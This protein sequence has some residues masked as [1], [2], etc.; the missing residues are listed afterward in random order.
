[1]TADCRLVRPEVGPGAAVL[2]PG[3]VPQG[4]LQVGQR[5]LAVAALAAAHQRHVGRVVPLVGHVQLRHVQL[6]VLPHREGALAE[7]LSIVTGIY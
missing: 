6:L 3:L 7:Q 2:G 5:S 4:L 1:M